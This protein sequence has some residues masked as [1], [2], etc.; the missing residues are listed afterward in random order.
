MAS[1]ATKKQKQKKAQQKRLRERRRKRGEAVSSNFDLRQQ[2]RRRTPQSWDGEAIEDQA[3]FDDEALASLPDDIRSQAVSIRDSLE[4]ACGTRFYQAIDG[5]SSIPRKSPLS[6]WRLF[7]RG[8]VSWLQ[9]E[10]SSAEEVWQRLD[11]ERRPGR[12]SIALMASRPAPP[13]TSADQPEESSDVVDGLDDDLQSSA[14]LLRRIR[15]ERKAIKVSKQGTKTL[16]DELNV[17]SINWLV[18]FSKEFREV[19]PSLV[20]A[21]ERAALARAYAQDDPEIFVEACA[22]FTGPRHDPNNL[23]LSSFYFSGFDDAEMEE[24]ADNSMDKYL[25]EELPKNESLPKPLRNAIASEIHLRE[26]VSGAQP[27]FRGM[28][29]FLA[30]DE[31][32]QTVRRHFNAAAKAYP[33][34][35]AAYIQHS[36]WIQSKLHDRMNQSER[37]PHEK[38]LCKVMEQWAAGIPND[39]EPR[40]W[41][42]DYLLENDESDK[43]KKHVEWVENSR[44]SD[45]RLRMV[46]W[47]WAVLEAMRLCRRKTSLGEASEALE[48][49]AE[50]WPE[51]LSKQ[52]Y[53]YL[54]AALL[55]RKKEKPA[56]ED[57]WSKLAEETGIARGTLADACMMLAAAQRMH[58]PT[59]DLK[60]LRLPVDD[61]LK[62][63]SKVPSEQLIELCQFYWDIQRT[64][65]LYPAFR[66]HGRKFCREFEERIRMKPQ[67]VTDKLETTAI[68]NVVLLFSEL[69]LW[70]DGYDVK[71]PTWVRNPKTSAHPALVAARVNAF[72][73]TTYRQRADKLALDSKL[74]REAVAAQKDPYRKSWFGRMA[75]ELEEL[76]ED[77]M[78]SGEAMPRRNPFL[79]D[80]VDVD[81]EFDGPCNC[82]KCRA[83]RGEVNTE[84]ETEPQPSTKKDSPSWLDWNEDS[85]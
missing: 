85:K 83:A 52:W 84:T 38:A 39:S 61:A 35:R 72:L 25:N 9:S 30:P 13:S 19:E 18:S 57:R 68:Q 64:G 55:L 26:A 69:R 77:A 80:E 1:K 78:A 53:P 49:V 31:D 76:I 45:I 15:F 22:K 46:P 36:N 43:A 50:R 74:L 20:T 7:I 62:K 27:R 5:V 21:F 11:P 12:I 48:R 10:W 16:P 24:I 14:K 28:M 82:P 34:N 3:V 71:L 70:N 66:M 47:K 63:V 42:I 41:L 81:D 56:F 58:V 40:I 29:A 23:L 60:P 17:R 67:L 33:S 4:H 37:A 32:T 44:Q 79:D 73:L 2:V 6:Q 54:E 75:T 8:L 65:L 59:A 51:W